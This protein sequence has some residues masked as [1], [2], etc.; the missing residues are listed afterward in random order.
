LRLFE[1]KKIS[2]KKMAVDFLTTNYN[3]EKKL[4]LNAFG[5][6]KTFL[7]IVADI[8][9]S[10]LNFLFLEIFFLQCS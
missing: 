10:H 2:F 4:A 9:F 1:V 8:L 6:Q 3:F 7:S 5:W